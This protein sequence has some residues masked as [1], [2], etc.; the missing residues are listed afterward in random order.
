MFSNNNRSKLLNC[1][2]SWRVELNTSLGNLLDI[3]LEGVVRSFVT[4]RIQ[5]A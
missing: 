2:C 5:I 4:N 1:V 3:I